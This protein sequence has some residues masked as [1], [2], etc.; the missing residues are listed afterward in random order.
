METTETIRARD[1]R[2]NEVILHDGRRYYI[3]AIDTVERFSGNLVQLSGFSK[4]YPEPRVLFRGL[5]PG[6]R[7][8]AI[9]NAKLTEG[10]K[11]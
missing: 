5:F 2:L 1:V 10:V 9:R 11:P 4:R 8:T 6:A 7:L 3:T